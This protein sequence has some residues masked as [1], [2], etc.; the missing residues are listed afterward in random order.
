MYKF[1]QALQ[2]PEENLEAYHS[3][4]RKLAATCNFENP[5]EEIKRQIIQG[6]TSSSLRRHA[7]KSD[8][9]TLTDL[10]AK[11]KRA[12]V[13]AVQANTMEGKFEDLST[14]LSDIT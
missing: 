13:V 5:N 2:S 12:E 11:G 6:C 3:R 4:L 14:K 10:L 1:R 7:L 9:L 8:K